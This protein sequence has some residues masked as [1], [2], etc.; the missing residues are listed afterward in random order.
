[1]AMALLT[2]RNT[3]DRDTG[4]SP[5]Q[6]LFAHHLRDSVP[7]K[8]EGLRLRPEWLL[9]RDARELALA[10]RHEVRGAQ[11]DEHVRVLGPLAFLLVMGNLQPTIDTGAQSA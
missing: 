2:Y 8:P 1:M 7:C 4:L 11:L 3:P 6:V 10:R 5:A 9:T